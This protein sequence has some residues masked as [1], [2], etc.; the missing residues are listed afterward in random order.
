MELW[1]SHERYEPEMWDL[2]VSSSQVVVEI[3]R[4]NL[5]RV[6]EFIY[7]GIVWQKENT[8]LWRTLENVNI[9]MFI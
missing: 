9:K 5:N 2:T 7:P 3:V 8:E 4:V 1:G 6:S